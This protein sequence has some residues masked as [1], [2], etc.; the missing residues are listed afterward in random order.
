MLLFFDREIAAR[1][2]AAC[3]TLVVVRTEFRKDA[4]VSN[5]SLGE[6]PLCFPS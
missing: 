5:E 1:D 6:E 2:T 3:R 4:F